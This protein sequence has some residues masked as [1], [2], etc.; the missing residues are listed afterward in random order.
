MSATHGQGLI[1]MV[2]N[3]LYHALVIPDQ[4]NEMLPIDQYA[5]VRAHQ[6]LPKRFL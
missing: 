3:H 1:A 2:D 5:A 6:A 4:F